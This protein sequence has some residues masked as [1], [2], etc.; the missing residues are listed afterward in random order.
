[1]SSLSPLHIEFRPDPLNNLMIFNDVN[2]SV[3]LSL[4]N[5]FFR[6]FADNLR[7]FADL[8]LRDSKLF[9]YTSFVANHNYNHLLM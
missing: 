5:I 7:S 2:S 3:S 4:R 8:I 9:E 6:A 1:M